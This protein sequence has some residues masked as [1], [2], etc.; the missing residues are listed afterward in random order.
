MGGLEDAVGGPLATTGHSRQVDPGVDQFRSQFVADPSFGVTT[1]ALG[2][3]LGR[4]L[5]EGLVHVHRGHGRAG[6][7]GEVGAP[8]DG[9][10]ARRRAVDTDDDAHERHLGVVRDDHQGDGRV[11]GEVLGDRTD[12]EQARSAAVT[13]A[14][15]DDQT[16]AV[17]VGRPGEYFTGVA[18]SDIGDRGGHRRRPGSVGGIQAP[19]LR[20]HRPVETKVVAGARHRRA[21]QE[22]VGAVVPADSG[23]P[24]RCATR[25]LGVVVAH[26]DPV[27]TCGHHRR[28]CPCRSRSHRRAKAGGTTGPN[29]PT[30]RCLRESQAGGQPSDEPGPAG[31]DA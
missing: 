15:G 3:G 27:A 28:S 16:R 21:Q 24:L 20:P 12:M 6:C 14:T 30:R 8:G 7:S 17:G 19:P 5:E 31:G 23:S 22:H 9:R 10:P 1:P 29:V 26:H 18:A 25:A 4:P 11:V 13:G 2:I